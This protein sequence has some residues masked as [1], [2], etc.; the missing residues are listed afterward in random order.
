MSIRSLICKIYHKKE[1]TGWDIVAPI[2]LGLMCI[3]ST[4]DVISKWH[5]SIFLGFRPQDFMF[6]INCFVI[7]IISLFIG[8][9]TLEFISTIL[10]KPII[11]CDKY[12]KE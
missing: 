2:I 8:A 12:K 7:I 5:E 6:T 9:Y 4:T 1:V 10:S 3:Y 11:K